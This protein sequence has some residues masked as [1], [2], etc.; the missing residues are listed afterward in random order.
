[1]LKLIFNFILIWLVFLS[2]LGYVAY[3]LQK[4]S[5]LVAEARQ[6]RLYDR[7]T[8]QIG[9]VLPKATK[10][11]PFT[12]AEL[13]DIITQSID[14]NAFYD[15]TNQA[16]TAY[17]D[18]LTGRADTLTFNYNFTPTKSRLNDTITEKLLAKYNNLPTCQTKDLH[19]WSTANGLPSCQLPASNVQSNDVESAF[20]N[21]AT[22]LTRDLPDQLTAGVPSPQLLQ[23]RKD[24]IEA[25]KVIKFIWLVT[26]AFLA[27]YLL[28]FRS[29]AFFSLAVIFLIAGLLE[30]G[31]SLIGWEWLR[32]LVSDSLTKNNQAVAAFIVDMVSAGIEV[33]KTLLGNLSIIT[34]S[35]GGLFLIL[36][37]VYAVKRKAKPVL[38]RLS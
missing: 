17:L 28:I 1:M 26:A 16:A 25:L 23:T 12:D 24:V 35:L 8:G 21:Q 11:S 31:F 7:L 30:I 3:Q 36:G 37:V 27:L 19:T 13:K 2:S 32:R 9:A 15:F 10:D 34:L 38:T 22:T 29:R 18:W 20:R 5:F 6:V 14:A 4:P 33:L